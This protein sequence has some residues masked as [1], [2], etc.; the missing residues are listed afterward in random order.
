MVTRKKVPCMGGAM[1]LVVE[2]KVIVAMEHTSGGSLKILN[3]C[4]LP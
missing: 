2:Q 3:K 1:D 4:R